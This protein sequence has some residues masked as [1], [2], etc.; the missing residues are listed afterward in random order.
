MKPK[1]KNTILVASLF[2]V[3]TGSSIW[4][5]YVHQPKVHRKVVNQITLVDSRLTHRDYLLDE[6]NTLEKKLALLD[7]L[8]ANNDKVIPFRLTSHDAYSEII[9]IAQSFSEQTEMNMEHMQTTYSG[10]FG[11]DYF[12][13]KGNGEFEDVVKLIDNLENARNLYKVKNANLKVGTSTDEVGRVNYHIFFDIEVEAYFTNDE[14]FS[15]PV[16]PANLNEH[17]NMRNFFNPLIY[18]DIP[19]N[20]DGLMEVDGASLL[21]IIPDGAFIVDKNGNSYTLLEGD[22]VYLGVLTK[23]DQENKICEF[24]LNRGGIIEQVILR[25]KNLDRKETN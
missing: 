24:L 5:V 16:R 4:Y 13:I 9:N 8:L 20:Y 6:V 7:T 15:I 25:I 18:S 23:I 17:T 21:A 2:V 12:R 10:S 14:N 19:P 3:I 1:V 22:E 11:K